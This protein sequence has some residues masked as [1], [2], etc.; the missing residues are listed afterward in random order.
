[1]LG[2]LRAECSTLGRVSQE[3]SREGDSSPA[4]HTSFDAVQDTVDF[5]GY[6]HTQP[7][8]V[9]L[10]INQ[11][12]QIFLLRDTLS[13]LPAQPVFVF[14]IAPVQTQDLAHGLF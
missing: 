9:G 6:K 13:P 8:H 7:A 1:M 11:H 4:S 12:P 3:E 2:S 10:L 5:L 14:G